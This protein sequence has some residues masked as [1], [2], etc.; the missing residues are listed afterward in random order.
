MH[1]LDVFAHLRK[2]E[3]LETLKGNLL[4]PPEISIEKN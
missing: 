4:K 1:R 3:Q 2:I